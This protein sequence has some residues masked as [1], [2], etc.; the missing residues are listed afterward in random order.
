MSQFLWVED[1]GSKNDVRTFTAS[2]FGAL[3]SGAPT[4]TELKGVLSLSAFL[5]KR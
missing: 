1:F 5:L 4:T 2:V 3:L